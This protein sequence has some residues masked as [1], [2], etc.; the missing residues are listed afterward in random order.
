MKKGMLATV[1][2][3]AGLVACE[4]GGGD[5]Q[6]A[7]GSTMVDTAVTSRTVQDTTVMQVETDTTVSVDT[8][9]QDAGEGT[10]QGSRD[11]ARIGGGAVRDTSQ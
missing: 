9:I 1:A 5:T 8:S 6:Q 3:M 11:S 2:L 10:V 7:G 4:A